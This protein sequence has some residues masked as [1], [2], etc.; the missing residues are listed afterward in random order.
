MVDSWHSKCSGYMSK[1][2]YLFHL[3][4][5][6]LQRVLLKQTH[7]TKV[8]SRSSCRDK[9]SILEVIGLLSQGESSKNQDTDGLR[10]LINMVNIH[11]I[12]ITNTNHKY[13]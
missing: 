13:K 4:G 9:F 5:V 3:A 1:K 11:Q 7:N 10:W 12:H 2:E 6:L 8:T